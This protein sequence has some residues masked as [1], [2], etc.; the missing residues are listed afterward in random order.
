MQDWQN[1]ENQDL[2]NLSQSL[3]IFATGNQQFFLSTTGS[4]A[5]NKSI[6]WP[7]M[8]S[9]PYLVIGHLSLQHVFEGERTMMKQLCLL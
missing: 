7:L 9:D 2:G 8:S 3:P 5:T 1:M 4:P 6:P